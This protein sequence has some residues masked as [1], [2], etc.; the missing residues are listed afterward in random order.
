MSE[1]DTKT[2]TGSTTPNPKSKSLVVD[3]AQEKDDSGRVSP[4]SSEIE[5]DGTKSLV[6]R[7]STNPDDPLNW[8]WK[9]KHAVLISIIPG[10]L[11]SDWTLTWGT[12]VFQLQ[13][14]EW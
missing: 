2:A 7:P 13:A 3:K 14:P 6:P 11:L 9:K 10:C 4:V 5:A 1:T 12:T 8:S